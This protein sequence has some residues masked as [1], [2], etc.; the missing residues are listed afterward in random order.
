MTMGTTMED[1]DPPSIVAAYPEAIFRPSGLRYETE[2]QDFV[3]YYDQGSSDEIDAGPVLEVLVK[4][5]AAAELYG[6]Y[7]R[8]YGL[9]NRAKPIL[10]KVRERL[11][12]PNLW[13]LDDFQEAAVIGSEGRFFL[14]LQR[15]GLNFYVTH[16]S[17]LYSDNIRTH[18]GFISEVRREFRQVSR[19]EIP[20]MRLDGRTRKAVE[21]LFTI[22]ADF[23]A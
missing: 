4:N 15:R 19:R 16:L 8:Y 13:F 5:G 10:R 2:D 18:E 14:R 7:L 6:H 1:R 17:L 9:K 11:T 3:R 21:K 23:R 20:A 12:D 22:A